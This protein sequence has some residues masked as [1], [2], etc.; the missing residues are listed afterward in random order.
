[1]AMV[2]D[3]W[4]SAL[5]E[6]YEKIVKD[7]GLELYENQF[8]DPNRLMRRGVVFAG[9]DLGVIAK[10]IREKKPYYVLSGIMPT[11]DKIHFGTKMVIENI[12]YFQDHGAAET[13]VLVADLEAAATR[14]V[15]LEEAQKRALQFHIPAYIAFGLDPKKTIFYFQSQNMK[16][17]QLA[18]EFAK[19][20]TLNE[21]R[22]IYGSADPGR[23][24]AAV[25]QA[26]DMLFPQLLKDKRMPGIIP[27]GIDQDP[28]LRLA[29][30]LA[31][32]FK[33]KY[34]FAP[35][36]SL[37]HKYTPSLDG[38]LKMSKSLPE[39]AIDIPEDI[40]SVKRKIMRAKSG[41]RDTL[42]EHR[43]KGGIP[44]DDMAFELLKQH[45]VED[46]AELATM[47]RSY[48]SGKMTTTELK[49]ITCDKMEAFMKDF[50]TKL[51]QAQKKV[52]KLKF[53]TLSI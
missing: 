31:Q 1:M 4:G 48:K 25:A 14:G 10:C 43:K 49:T 24:M 20:I 40:A 52:S 38:G 13:Y 22:A 19:K 7:F 30:D 5:P 46:D 29:R 27:V 6:S 50:E 45:L 15:T 47:Y 32:R 9:R 34:Q 35:L 42:E 18:Y 8:P 51:K 36:A 21:F 23:I 44:E 2:I 3:P 17:V 39:S 16:V 33:A 26:G 41:G 53:L 37:Y 11:N 28:H 12:K